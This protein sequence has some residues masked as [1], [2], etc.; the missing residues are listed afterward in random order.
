MASF[1]S[2]V[3]YQLFLRAFTNEGT[4]RAAGKLLPHIKDTGADYVYLCPVFVH[5]DDENR[6]GWSSR[7]KQ[8][9]L[10]NAKNP[11]RM[12]DYFHVDPEYG[13]DDDLR[14]F[15]N[16]A[17]ASGLR[18]MLDL[19]YF[20]CGPNAVFLEDHPD[21]IYRNEDG[22]P[23]LGEWCFPKLNYENRELREYLW[24]N[25]EYYVRDFG[26]DGYRCDVGDAVPLDFWAEG[27]RRIKAIN[28]DVLMLNE[29]C[30]REWTDGVFDCNYD[31]GFASA[32][33]KVIG[34][35]DAP[36][37]YLVE[38]R[39][40][41]EKNS[42]MP[43][44][45]SILCFDNHDITNDQYTHRYEEVFG[46]EAVD[47]ML[48]LCFTLDGI[49]FLSNANEIAD[50]PRHSTWGGS[51]TKGNLTI[52]WQNAVTVEGQ[53]RLAHVKGLAALHHSYRAIIDGKTEY[54]PSDDSGIFAFLRIAEQETLL[55]IANMKRNAVSADFSCLTPD[56]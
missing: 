7:Q 5:D 41:Y 17:H 27:V 34:K 21:F 15:I 1:H 44:K 14:S 29:G 52:D 6:D 40:N 35:E 32:M 3:I 10:D 20:H 50:T 55:C 28:P 49:P 19:V 9:K 4:L 54:L 11:Y 47:V 24:K 12:K 42:L 25:M 18:V 13:T 38:Y 37:A 56:A 26:C 48:F 53:T 36:A 31:F 22:T 39:R 8:S 51:T 45:K 23:A 46:H 43:G 30:K 2:P 33:A 16:D